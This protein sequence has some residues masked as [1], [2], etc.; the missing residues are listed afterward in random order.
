MV[1]EEHATQPLIEDLDEAA[2]QLPEPEEDP[3]LAPGSPEVTAAEEPNTPAAECEPGSDDDV[4]E[5]PL[6][7][8]AFCKFS[9]LVRARSSTPTLAHSS[10]LPFGRR[11][12]SSLLGQTPPLWPGSRNGNLCARSVASPWRRR[13]RRPRSLHFLLPRLPREGGRRPSLER[14]QSRGQVQR[15]HWRRG[16]SGAFCARCCCLRASAWR[17]IWRRNIR[18]SWRSSGR[19]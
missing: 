14:Q 12:P 1:E 9:C 8:A 6:P 18:R 3:P 13:P 7:M 4:V 10:M 16:A 17:P 11:R 19:P 15:L 5:A 2:T